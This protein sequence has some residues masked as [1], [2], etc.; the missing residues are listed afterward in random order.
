MLEPI[1]V[2]KSYADVCALERCDLSIASGQTRVLIG[3]S[4]CGKST[5]LHLIIGLQT[6]DE[7]SIHFSGQRLEQDSLPALRQQ[8]GH[9]IQDGA[10][11]H[12]FV[13]ATMWR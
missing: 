11:S 6:P 9:V 13:R 1:Q 10:Y 8:M 3:P 12:T 5:I 4:G 2:S 7:G